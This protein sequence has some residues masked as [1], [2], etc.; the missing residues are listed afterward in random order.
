MRNGDLFDLTDFEHMATVA[1]VVWD[2]ERI[3]VLSNNSSHMHVAR[4]RV[5]AGMPPTG[6]R[7]PGILLGSYPYFAD[8]DWKVAYTLAVDEAMFQAGLYNRRRQ[9]GEG[10]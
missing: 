9:R 2:G 8:D 1:S 7:Q 10:D 4:V 3:M 6:I 5:D